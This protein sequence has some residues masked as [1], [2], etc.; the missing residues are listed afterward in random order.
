MN[1]ANATLTTLSPKLVLTAFGI[2]PVRIPA[3][4]SPT[5]CSVVIVVALFLQPNPPCVFC[6]LFVSCTEPDHCS[7]QLP[8][9][10]PRFKSNTPAEARDVKV[11]NVPGI[12]TCRSGNVSVAI[13]SSISGL[14][15]TV[16]T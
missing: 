14:I 16:P 3:L 12:S 2:K 13:H 7:F 8:Q 4:L 15:V 9:T 10:V 1:G 6:V 5:R 11:S